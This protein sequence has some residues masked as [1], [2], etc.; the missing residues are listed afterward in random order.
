MK[1]SAR[2]HAAPP[3]PSPARPAPEG[4]C[5]R[6]ILGP[7]NTGKTHLALERMLAHDS[8]IIGFPLRLLA[9]EN[10]ERMVQAKGVRAVALITGEEKIIPPHARWFSCTVEAM[11]TTP[12]PG[13]QPV[14]FVAV[15]EIQLC[16]DPERGH[17]FTDRLLNARGAA[18][19]LFLGA[20]TIAPLLK[21]LI[22]HIEIDTRPRL[23]ALSGVGH[24]RLSR[25]PP[26]SAIVTFSVAEV[27]AIAEL[28]R[29]KRGGCAVV[30]GQ[31]SPRTR[32]AQV[33]LYQN[34]EVDYLV[35]TDA[36]GMGLN[37]DIHHVAFAGLSKFDGQR[38]RLL[39]A[40]EVAQIAGRA[41]RG[42][43]DGTFGTT[44]TCP[45]LNETMVEAVEEHRFD[46]LQSLWWRNSALD[47][48][49]LTTLH[50]SLCRKPP[51]RCLRPAEPA[52]DM[53]CLHAFMQDSS[54]KALANTPN[55]VRLLWEVCQIPDFRK[56]GEDSHIRQCA[57]IFTLLARRGHLPSDWLG[58]R[59]HGMDSTVGDLDSLMQRLMGIRIWSYVAARSDWVE[60]AAHWQRHTRQLEDTLSDALHDRLTARF[61]DRR[62][63][64][65]A[66]RLEESDGKPLLSAMS[67]TGEIIVEGHTVGHMRGF[68]F[69]PDAEAAR[70]D[71]PLILRAARRAART[72][73]PHLVA[74]FAQADDTE[75]TLD[76]ETGI[77]SWQGEAVAYLRSGLS[78]LQ[79]DIAVRDA[80]FLDAGQKEKIRARLARFVT[81]LIRHELAPL[82][83]A[84]AAVQAHPLPRG[85]VHSL[86]EQGGVTPCPLLPFLSS[87][88]KKLLARLHIL[89]TRDVLFCSRLLRP[90]PMALRRLL[91][92]IHQQTT[93][94][95]LPPAGAV[96]VLC[97][98]PPSLSDQAAYL[99]LGW[100]Y[101]AQTLLRLDRVAD[102]RADMESLAR[103]SAKPA[104]ANLA[105][106]LGVTKKALPV[107]LKALGIRLYPPTPLPDGQPG[108]P[109]PLLILPA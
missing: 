33:A 106:R 27:Y 109:A 48:S 86:M 93:L 16:A 9:R 85:L 90:A 74:R 63:A 72:E 22:P 30:M 10:Y 32:N 104:P 28:I 52:A 69:A 46:P 108:P 101:A 54:I 55:L 73:M 21:T 26:R 58:A 81:A 82:F 89:H 19:T 83:R 41:G 99:S 79:P 24:N 47:F 37:M 51:M 68:A 97:A 23:S 70:M 40:A 42:A 18:E 71:Q 53:L 95:S 17:I 84:E 78:V 49:S 103:K 39:S 34:R 45:P 57:Q 44:G 88:E 87:V 107:I 38:H 96:C 36:I 3:E 94:P 102:I 4:A 1:V 5:I 61:V 29:R 31:L 50:A 56:L 105:S 98:M 100:L 15:D 62:A 13:N 91:L 11:P 77:L 67:R 76:T 6:A 75:L 60:N 8:G 20:D 59:L 25:L 80:E 12:L 35:A 7:T 2:Q 43:R 66:R 92:G 65:L 64:S 14:D